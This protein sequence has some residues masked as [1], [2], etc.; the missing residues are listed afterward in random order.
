ME[1]DQTRMNNSC[2]EC[3]CTEAQ[4]LADARALGFEEEFRVGVYTC[5]QIA[6][7]ANEQWLAC[8]EGALQD[9]DSVRAEEPAEMEPVLV[10]V[11]RR[12]ALDPRGERG[13]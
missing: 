4:A 5:C 2:D 7:W 8:V 12:R 10:P 9:T 6:R 3:G 1:N 13:R 11:R